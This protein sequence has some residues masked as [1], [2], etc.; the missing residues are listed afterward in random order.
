MAR[1]LLDPGAVEY[2]KLFG[3]YPTSGGLLGVAVDRGVIGAAAVLYERRPVAFWANVWLGLALGVYLLLAFRAIWSWKTWRQGR[4]VGVILLAAY[5]LVMSGG[6]Q[7]LG[8]F[9][10]PV[11][12][13]VCL[14]AGA[15][16]SRFAARLRRR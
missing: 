9:R 13:L 1:T 11:M 16:F 14:L 3:A 15:A 6:P 12:P 5:F 2:M 4:L 8:R 7:A 10:H